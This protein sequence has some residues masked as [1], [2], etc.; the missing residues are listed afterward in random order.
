MRLTLVKAFNGIIS[1]SNQ[2]LCGSSQVERYS[3]TCLACFLDQLESVE[4]DTR[5]YVIKQQK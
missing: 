2:E 3:S 1:Q 5:E 4:G